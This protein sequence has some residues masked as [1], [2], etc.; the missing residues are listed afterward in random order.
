MRR[1]FRFVTFVTVV[2]AGSSCGSDALRQ[3]RAPMLLVVDALEAAPTGGHGANSFTGTLLSDVV[4]VSTDP[5]CSPSPSASCF[6]VFNDVGR[7][8]LASQP[9][10]I[11]IE[12][13]SN[14]QVTINR[15]HVDF[16]RADGQNSPGVDVPYSFDGGVTGTVPETGTLQ[17]TFELVRHTSKEESPLIQLRNSSQIIHTIAHVTFYGQDLVG[18]AISVTGSIGVDFGNFGD[19]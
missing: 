1:T 11:S 15:Y 4:V 9:K 14:N 12:P 19:Q 8:T 6:T 7:V 2:A 10:N 13:T 17:L 3:S 18:N 5:A 16:V